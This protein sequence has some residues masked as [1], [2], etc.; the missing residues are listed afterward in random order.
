[1]SLA[2]RMATQGSLVIVDE[3]GKGTADVDGLSLLA[4]TIQE[5]I[6]R[7]E[8]CPTIFLSTHFS[9][10]VNYL[11]RTQGIKM[12]VYQ[13][14]MVSLMEECRYLDHANL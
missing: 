8:N 2:L 4:A 7:K 12:Q 11:K 6:D 5:F 9:S 14:R 13:K 1:M 3:F 10:V